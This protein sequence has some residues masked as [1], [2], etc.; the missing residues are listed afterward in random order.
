M[1]GFKP[2][3][4]GDFQTMSELLM[5]NK[6]LEE[7][8][9]ALEEKNEALEKE[10][11]YNRIEWK[12]ALLKQYEDMPRFKITHKFSLKDGEDLF[13][14]EEKYK[15]EFTHTIFLRVYGGSYPNFNE[16]APISIG[17]EE[18]GTYRDRATAEKVS[19]RLTSGLDGVGDQ[20]V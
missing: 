4:A 19:D 1:F 9:E 11:D 3:K 13:T 12:K 15:N 17:Y 5:K 20:R 18:V 2:T 6:D 16:P 14:L 10:R 8:N 7:K